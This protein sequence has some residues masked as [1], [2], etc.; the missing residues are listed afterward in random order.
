[1]KLKLLILLTPFLLYGIGYLLLNFFDLTG[2]CL[3]GQI[4]GDKGG[5]ELRCISDPTSVAWALKNFSVYLFPVAALL[6]F[7][8]KETIRFWLEKFAFFALP[9]G[10]LI[11]AISNN[12]TKTLWPFVPDS[13]TF[14]VWFGLFFFVVSTFIIF[15][16][17]RKK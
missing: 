2:I 12:N 8:T 3:G 1:M 7:S 15:F 6:F 10:I 17:N 13:I 14:S 11:F 4:T 9:V 16:S 5:L